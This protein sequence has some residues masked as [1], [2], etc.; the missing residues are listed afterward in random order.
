[1]N[2]AWNIV[3][4]GG[5]WYHVD[6]TWD[7]PTIRS[8]SGDTKS[9]MLYY[10]YFMKSDSGMPKDHYGWSGGIAC[11]NASYDNAFW[12]NAMGAMYKVNNAF[13]YYSNGILY[14]TS[15]PLIYGKPE[16]VV[17]PKYPA[18]G[19]GE[20]VINKTD[21][22]IAFVSEYAKVCVYSL[23]TGKSEEFQITDGGYMCYVN[24][25]I[26]K[27]NAL[28]ARA[29][30]RN[31]KTCEI[32]LF[33]FDDVEINPGN[34]K[35]DS[36]KYANEKKIMSGT[37]NTTFA[38]D[39]TLTRSMFATVLY[40]LDGAKAVTYKARFSDVGPGKWYSSAIT[41]AADNKIVNGYPNGSFGINDTITREQMATMLL[42]YANYKKYYTKQSADVSKFPD[43]SKVSSWAL[44]AVK[45]AVGSKLIS[46]KSNNGQVYLDPTSGAT[47]AECATIMKN[48][49]ENSYEKMYIKDK[50]PDPVFRKW[51]EENADTNKDGIITPDELGVITKLDLDY[52]NQTSS[53]LAGLESLTGLEELSL[54]NASPI[55]FDISNNK[56]LRTLSLWSVNMERFKVPSLSDLNT[57]SLIECNINTADF[58][59]CEAI[60]AIN[61]DRGTVRSV[62]LGNKPKLTSFKANDSQLESLDISACTKLYTLEVAGSKLKSLDFN[63]KNLRSVK[64][65]YDTLAHSK[66]I[67]LSSECSFFVNTNS[68]EID[69]SGF[70]LF[71]AFDSSKVTPL[72][73]VKFAGTIASMSY[74]NAAFY[75]RG[76][77]VN[78]TIYLSYV[79]K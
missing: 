44:S 50:F 26:K 61:I 22:A 70:G 40:N 35:Y 28:Y 23:S 29:D 34:W 5:S 30:S 66:I 59:D 62:L 65:D 3:N 36:V 48:F 1:M 57:A 2:H 77:G 15:S 18:A 7:D 31:G 63:A 4:V 32:S 20:F 13:Y 10:K 12:A 43:A 79:Q 33:K 16:V 75:Y 25:V 54:K 58:R 21:H 56:K 78:Y 14:K 55:N 42:N 39:V 64:A 46:G 45:W 76:G 74:D 17:Q 53:N 52:T 68:K 37:S 60:S 73:G 19:F 67:E 38:P 71:G 24:E 69:F 72:Y 27:N 8:K 9:T 11:T 6:C 51:I 49:C 41:W 47:R